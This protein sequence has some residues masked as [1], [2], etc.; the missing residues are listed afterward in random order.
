ME[1]SDWILLGEDDPN[2]ALLTKRALLEADLPHKVVH[3]RD[4]VEVIDCLKCRGAFSARL[5]G[6]PALVL[7]DL[8]MPR[9]DGQEVLQ[10][11]KSDRNLK[12][13]PVVIYTAS[14]IEGDIRR[15]YE[16]GA[17]GYVIKSADYMQFKKEFKLL[18]LYWAT[19]NYATTC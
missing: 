10:L 13:I 8:K 6:N 3:A 1:Q 12:C 14:P 7:L 9:L 17:N 2:D 4:G 11:I 19:V 16:S 15:A 18:G 5:P